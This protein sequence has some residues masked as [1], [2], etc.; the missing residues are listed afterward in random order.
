MDCL[1][2]L[3][4]QALQGLRQSQIKN[5]QKDMDINAAGKFLCLV[6]A[7]AEYYFK[8]K[9]MPDLEIEIPRKFLGGQ[10]SHGGK[11]LN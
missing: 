3:S 1:E 4:E 9:T 11:H 7:K 2:S 5:Q 10:T 6:G 8:K